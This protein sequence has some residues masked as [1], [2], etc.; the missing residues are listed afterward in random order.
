MI[1]EKGLFTLIELLVV[2][3]IIAILASLL[4]PSLGTARE[5]AKKTACQGQMRQAGT[6]VL[7][8]TMDY[9]DYFPYYCPTANYSLWYQVV[10]VGGLSYK[11]GKND[12]FFCPS[13]KSWTEKRSD[14]WMYGY[15]SY[16]ANNYYI[17][18]SGSGGPKRTVDFRSPSATVYAVESA[19]C[20]NASPPQ[21]Y[22][23]FHVI[24][25][26]DPANPMPGAKHNGMRS[27][28]VLW[29]DGHLNSYLSPYPYAYSGNSIFSDSACGYRWS[30]GVDGGGSHNKWDTK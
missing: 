3:A 5:S 15:I 25:W 22:G 16:G 4:L 20:F 11:R 28:N 9:R 29:M 18:H 30:D 1:R 14:L 7:T 19:A 2:I 24:C 13:D 26:N 10:D 17:S 21:R 6:S 12:V 27:L 8:Y 23:Y